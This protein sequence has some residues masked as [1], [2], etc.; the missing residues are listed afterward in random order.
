MRTLAGILAV[1]SLSGC[2]IYGYRDERP[3]LS[4]DEVV[5]MK[6]AGVADEVI[7]AKISTSRVPGPL[8]APE[9]VRLK[10]QGLGD[11]ILEALVEASAAPPPVVYR[12]VY[13]HDPYGPYPYGYGPD[14]HAGYRYGYHPYWGH[15]RWMH[16]PRTYRAR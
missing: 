12:H 7:A 11:G 5:A 8:T 9:I 1:A 16:R 14:L 3:V 4:V 10:D 6:Q 2:G 15:R 13:H